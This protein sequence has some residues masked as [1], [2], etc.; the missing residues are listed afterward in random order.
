MSKISKGEKIRRK[1]EK[2]QKDAGE[3][4]EKGKTKVKKF[5]RNSRIRQRNLTLKKKQVHK[6]RRK[7]VMIR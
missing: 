3:T 7:A 2:R 5:K 4:R 6:E 1:R